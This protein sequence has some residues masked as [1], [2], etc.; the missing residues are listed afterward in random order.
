MNGAYFRYAEYETYLKLNPAVIMNSR[1]P[2]FRD[3]RKQAIVFRYN[4]VDKE[5]SKIIND[6]NENYSV[7]NVKYFNTK[8]EVTSHLNFNSD[9]QFSSGFGKFAGEV[10]YRKLFNSN[11]QIN[12]RLYA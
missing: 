8:T 3:N 11:R 7:F 2:N 1:E 5:R 6:T 9:I 10:Q 12:L 4:I